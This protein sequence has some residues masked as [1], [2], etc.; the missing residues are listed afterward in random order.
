MLDRILNIELSGIAVYLFLL[1]LQDCLEMD[2]GK[3]EILVFLLE[4]KIALLL[5]LI[6]V[7]FKAFL[8]KCIN[9]FFDHVFEEL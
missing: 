2:G 7:S 4:I 8:R 5:F 9:E 3:S 1:S 6:Y